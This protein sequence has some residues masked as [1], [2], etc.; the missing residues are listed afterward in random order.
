MSGGV[1]YIGVYVVAMKGSARVPLLATLF[2]HVSSD[3]FGVLVLLNRTNENNLRVF[4]TKGT[5]SVLT[6]G[7]FLLVQCLSKWRYPYVRVNLGLG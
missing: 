4:R 6:R 7:N 1:A 5:F 3:W 2:D